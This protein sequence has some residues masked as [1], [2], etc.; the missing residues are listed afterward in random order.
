MHR[1]A[2]N[3]AAGAAAN[4]RGANRDSI[5]SLVRLQHYQDRAA[6]ERSNMKVKYEGE[7][8]L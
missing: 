4:A 3:L 6:E 1:I 2:L 5:V 7:S 8:V